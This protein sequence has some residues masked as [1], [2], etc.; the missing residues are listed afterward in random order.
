MKP[1]TGNDAFFLYA[2]TSEQHMHTVGTI[3]LD[4]ST[5][6][7]KVTV[8]DLIENLQRNI[9][10]LPAWRQKLVEVP[11]SLTPPV[12]VD[13]PDFDFNNHVRHIALPAPGGREQLE[14]A[15]AD[16]ASTPLAQNRPLWESWFIE[17]LEGGR[18]AW[19]TKT[20]H[21]LADG[22]AGAQLMERLYDLEPDPPR[23]GKKDGH[24]RYVIRPQPVSAMEVLGKA[25]QAQRKSAPSLTQV[26][27]RGTRSML[28]RRRLANES[29]EVDQLVPK[30]LQSAPRLKFNRP[31]SEQRSVALGCVAM[32]DLKLIKNHYGVSL[33]DVVLAAGCLA[34]RRY[35]I[36]THDLPDEPLFCG[37]PVSLTLKAG[38]GKQQE[39]NAVGTMLVKLPVQ[40]SD[41]VE[42]IRTVHAGAV[43]SKRV[44]DE[45]FENLFNDFLGTLPPRLASGLLGLMFGRF[46][47]ERM[48]L[49]MN[50]LISNIPG[51]PKPLYMCGALMEASYGMGPITT[52][53]GPNITLM[54]YR[55][56]MGFSVQACRKLM[57]DVA[58]IARDFEDAVTQMRDRVL[59][60]TTAV[61]KAPRGRIKAPEKA[62]AKTP[63][64]AKTKV[65]TKTRAKT[66]KAPAR[67]KAATRN[68]AKAVTRAG[69][70][71]AG[72][73]A[74]IKAKPGTKA[75]AKPKPAAKARA[76]T[77]R[78]TR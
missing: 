27:V 26:I 57:P 65:G 18:I 58:N 32:D 45:T 23:D 70:V 41:E 40:A 73:R 46:L 8:H 16:I 60:E 34:L 37:V 24:V 15:I 56:R 51:P 25:L 53:M 9:D 29:A 44:F 31:I 43:E 2:E 5:A 12:L 62:R 72:T 13:D 75:K 77:K 21:C 54:S 4:P 11:L 19:V 38:A 7:R 55:G 10:D 14:Q 28:K 17:N 35:L 74:K 42:I 20:H 48:P 71:K 3:V 39:A 50:C 67:K 69:T 49:Q 30:P 66:N 22:V 6:P 33:N 61:V 63:T 52:A 59:V 47:A 64:K 68:V 1:L 76:G 78:T 36:A